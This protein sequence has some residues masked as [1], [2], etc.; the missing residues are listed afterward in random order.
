[1]FG[2]SWSK[3]IVVCL[4]MKDQKRYKLIQ[5][6]L[7]G[8]VKNGHELLVQETLKSVEYLTIGFMISTD[9]LMLIVMQ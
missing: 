8:V 2:W 9:F 5:R 3:M 7:G 6:F 4:V 1:M